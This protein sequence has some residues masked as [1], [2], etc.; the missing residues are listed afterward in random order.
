MI[1]GTDVARDIFKMYFKVQIEPHKY[2][3]SIVIL[4]FIAPPP[5][6]YRQ[7]LFDQR[8][9]VYKVAAHNLC[10]FFHLFYLYLR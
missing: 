1:A 4:C 7:P 10:G 6:S 5:L 3:Q 9:Q 8:I 2:D